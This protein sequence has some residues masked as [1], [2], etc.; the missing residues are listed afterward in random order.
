MKC[1]LIV[2]SFLLVMFACSTTLVSAGTFYSETSS[3]NI[4]CGNENYSFPTPIVL[5]NA[6]GNNDW[7]MF[8]NIYFNITSLNPINISVSYLNSNILTANMPNI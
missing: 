3:D 8:N 2:L 7:V 6:K 1:K 4:Q 5:T